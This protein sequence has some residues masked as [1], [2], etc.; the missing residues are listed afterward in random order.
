MCLVTGIGGCVKAED[1]NTESVQRSAK[2]DARVA[3]S[4]VHMKH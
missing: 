2:G 3:G 1:K 4:R